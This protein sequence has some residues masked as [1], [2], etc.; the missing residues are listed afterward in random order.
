MANLLEPVFKMAT[1]TFNSIKDINLIQEINLYERL[2]DESNKEIINELLIG[3][4]N[5]KDKE[6]E[7]KNEL[8]GRNMRASKP[9]IKPVNKVTFEY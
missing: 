3:C 5:E 2:Y 4:P 8:L 7:F 6:I 9:I 1:F